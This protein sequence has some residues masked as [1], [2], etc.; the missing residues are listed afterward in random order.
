M[1]PW[2]GTRAQRRW[3]T[4]T[5]TNRLVGAAYD[6]SGNLL[7]YQGSTYAW[8]VLGEITTVNTGTEQWVHTY[9]AA[10]ERVWSWRAA[11]SRVDT[12]ALRGIGN[13]V[14]SDFSKAGTGYSWEDYVYREGQL[15]A[16]KFSDGRTVHFNVDHLGS[17]RQETDA[18]GVVIKYREFWPYG[19]EATPPSGTEQMKFTGHE[20]D[21]GDPNSTADDLDYM[22]ARYYRPLMGRFLSVDPRAGSPWM[23]QT[24]NEFSYVAGNPLKYR[25][26]SGMALDCLFGSTS[27]AGGPASGRCTDSVEATGEPANPTINSVV[28]LYHFSGG[29]AP[30]EPR[31]ERTKPSDD[32]ENSNPSGCGQTIPQCVQSCTNRGLGQAL[33]FAIGVGNDGWDYLVGVTAAGGIASVLQSNPIAGRAITAGELGGVAAGARYAISWGG[34]TT[35]EEAMPFMARGAAAGAMAVKGAVAVAG[36]A[37]GYGIGTV[38]HCLAECAVNACYQY[39]LF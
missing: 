6:G 18:A 14:L 38:L 28:A 39:P 26:H 37:G 34:A 15:L 31:A 7:S 8:N 2:G 36:F 33:D 4:P 16:A 25:D 22:H 17:V 29:S 11:P 5:T 35:I 3:G 9:D 32:P 24:W 12:Y 30:S 19:E 10:G 20:R 13:E 27:G 21:L 1:I 23:A